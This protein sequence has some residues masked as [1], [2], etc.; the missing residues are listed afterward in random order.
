MNTTSQSRIEAFIAGGFTLINFKAFVQTLCHFI[1]SIVNGKFEWLHLVLGIVFSTIGVAVGI[2]ILLG[3][4][5]ARRWV[6]GFLLL[7]VAG[8]CVLSVESLLHIWPRETA[9]ETLMNITNMI[10][11]LSLLALPRWNKPPSVP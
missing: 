10:V 4:I 11:N 6:G 7:M 2:G 1:A 9:Q 8:S 5:G 3:N